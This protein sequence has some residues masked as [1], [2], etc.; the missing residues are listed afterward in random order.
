MGKLIVDGTGREKPVFR[1]EFSSFPDKKISHVDPNEVERVVGEVRK[2]KEDAEVGQKEATWIPQMDYE[3]SPMLFLFLTDAHDFSI[4]TNIEKLNKYLNIVKETPNMFLVT[5]GDDVDNFNVTLGKVATGVYEDPVESGI[6]GRAWAKKMTELD[7]MGKVGFFC[8]GNHQDW[9]YQQGNDWYETF[10][11]QMEAPI[12][13]SG[14]LVRV[15]FRKGAKYE[16]ATSHRYWGVSKLNPT[17]ACKRYLEHEYPTADVVLLGHTHQSEMLQFDRAGKDRIACIGGTL[18]SEDEYARKHG[19]GGRAGTPGMCIA[20]WPDHRE[21]Q[22]YKNLER[23]VE[24][25]LRR[26]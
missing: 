13:T 26:I 16:I 21:I 10:L 9:S 25:H 23:A 7:R 18:K 5:G 12:L 11:G 20:L 2:I 14:G 6:Q 22:G 17:N 15:Q 19:L 24:E 4:R 1:R 8:F 3:G